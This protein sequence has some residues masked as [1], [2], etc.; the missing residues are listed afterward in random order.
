[1]HTY[2]SNKY[3]IS[4][5]KYL[6][7]LISY[8]AKE[9]FDNDTVET[10]VPGQ[11]WPLVVRIVRNLVCRAWYIF[12]NP[13]YLCGDNIFSIWVAKQAT[14]EFRKMRQTSFFMSSVGL[15]LRRLPLAKKSPCI[16]R[17]Q[18]VR[19]FVHDNLL[20]A[21]YPKP[22]QSTP[23]PPILFFFKVTSQAVVIRTSFLPHTFHTLIHVPHPNLRDLSPESLV[24]K[25][26][27]GINYTS[28]THR[29]NSDYN[30]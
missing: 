22:H 16:F 25:S 12:H 6:W 1:M 17:T 19:C 2:Q 10:S 7:L 26:H 29:Q 30:K 21:P 20:H 13:P 8:G 18:I 11:Y 15:E 28:P 24:T 3:Q 23:L 14:A 27:E 5:V 9:G 4:L